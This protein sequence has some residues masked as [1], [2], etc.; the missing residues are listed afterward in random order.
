M[1]AEKAIPEMSLMEAAHLRQQR[2]EERV[3]EENPKDI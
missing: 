1:E 3:K 2:E